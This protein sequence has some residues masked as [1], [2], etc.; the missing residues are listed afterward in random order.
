MVSTFFFTFDRKVLVMT[1]ETTSSELAFKKAGRGGKCPR[2]G[3]EGN[4][5]SRVQKETFVSD[6]VCR[7]TVVRR[8]PLKEL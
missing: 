1:G 7:F 4:I 3:H 6:T 8:P 2:K 5:G